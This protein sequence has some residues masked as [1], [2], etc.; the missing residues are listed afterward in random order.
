ML[1]V[2]TKYEGYSH[3]KKLKQKNEEI[4]EDTS[5]TEDQEKPKNKKKKKKKRCLSSEDKAICEQTESKVVPLPKDDEILKS[6]ASITSLVKEADCGRNTN[7]TGQVF[8]K[9][10]DAG[11]D[12]VKKKSKKIKKRKMEQ[13]ETVANEIVEETV[14]DLPKKKKIK[15]NAMKLRIRQD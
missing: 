2:Q 7:K 4:V 11:Y 6:K 9:E 3:A 12:S 15:K 8:E 14:Y 5:L 10:A 13:A 1:L